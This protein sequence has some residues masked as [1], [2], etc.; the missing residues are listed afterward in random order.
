MPT[1]DCLRARPTED[2]IDLVESAQTAGYSPQY[3]RNLMF[4]GPVEDRP[5]LWKS[6]SGYWRA[7]PSEIKA[8]AE[9][10]RADQ[11]SEAS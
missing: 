5:P 3:L 11:R 1:R 10:R 2:S 6:R 9:R 4:K 7:Y 8:W